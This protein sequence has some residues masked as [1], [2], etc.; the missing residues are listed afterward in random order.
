MHSNQSKITTGK[1]PSINPTI[2]P[3]LNKIINWGA[4]ILFIMVAIVVYYFVFYKSSLRFEHF[5]DPVPTS[6]SDAIT[7]VILPENST[8]YEQ[9]LQ[10]Q[11]GTNIR[12]ICNM[13]PTLDT[14]VCKIGGVTFSY[15]HFPVQMIKM[16]D[17]TIL[18]VF[19]DGRMYSKDTQDGTIWVGPLDNSL[20]KSLVPLRMISITPDLS[21]LLGVGY[22]NQLYK[23][24]LDS[25]TGKLD[26]TALWKP[27]TNNDDVIYVIF[28]RDTKFMVTIN[29]QGKLFIKT[30]AN[31]T[32]DNTEVTNSK[33]DRPLLRLYYDNFGYMLAI[34]N[35]FNLYQ[36]TD[37]DWKKS[38][39][40]LER[41]A[42]TEQIND[43]IY[44][45]DGKLIALVF[46]PNQFMLKLMKQSQS[47]YLSSFMPLD[48]LQSSSGS[49]LDAKPGSNYVMS[50]GDVI[51]A[52]IG[53][54][55]ST[56]TLSDNDALDQDV[57]FAF[58]QQSLKD[59]G[60]LRDFC[61]SRYNTTENES[62]NYEVLSQVEENSERIKLLKDVLDNL[63]KY[64]PDKKAIQET[65]PALYPQ[66]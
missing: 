63:I 19:N 34:D 22:D 48:I 10:E 38:G 52:K 65:Y 49:S 13:T 27:V 16:Q 36:F 51:A 37:K 4:V 11:F 28:D 43:I 57:V 24:T 31:I 15:L 55:N 1:N 40:N 58:N 21:Y 3:I 59:Q 42:N 26:A 54:I 60:K 6:I 35:A 46:Q 33:L 14:A 62:D 12:T 23:R 47:Y 56:L 17:G 8:V 20:P 5:Q 50:D 61:N 44:A 53:Y 39:L 32:T 29:T 25:T 30:N 7:P 2:N 45:N 9:S 66:E 41:G 18:G 64:D